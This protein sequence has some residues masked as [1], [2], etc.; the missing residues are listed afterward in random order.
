[1]IRQ[2]TIGEVSVT[3][4]EVEHIRVP[5]KSE[6][7]AETNGNFAHPYF[8]VGRAVL[9]GIFLLIMADFSGMFPVISSTFFI[10]LRFFIRAK[11]FFYGRIKLP[12]F[13]SI[14]S[15]ISSVRQGRRLTLRL[16]LV[17]KNKKQRMILPGMDG[18]FVDK[19]HF[20]AG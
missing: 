4:S 10:H 15:I 17:A 2:K 13:S 5:V 14:V 18:K 7:F 20:H 11:G 9:A 3:A 12:S 6:L 1:M 19:C 8:H 16:R